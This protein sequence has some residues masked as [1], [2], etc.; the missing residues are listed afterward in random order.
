MSNGLSI[1][2]HLVK[3]KYKSIKVC[4]EDGIIKEKI[5]VLLC[6]SLLFIL[7]LTIKIRTICN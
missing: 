7:N 5:H 2:I 1:V 4:K 6:L 3:L